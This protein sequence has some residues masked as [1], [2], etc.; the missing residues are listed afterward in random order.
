MKNLVEL[1]GVSK[2]Y[3]L[4]KQKIP[5]LH[6]IDLKIGRG[7]LISIIGPSGS[8]KS[9]LLHLLGLMDHADHGTILFEESNIKKFSENELAH[10]R[11]EKIG[12]VFQDFHL[13]D[14]LSIEDNIALPLLI[15]SG[16]NSLSPNQQ[17]KLEELMKKLGIWDRRHHRP[18]QISGGQ[19][20]RTAIA[21]ALISTPELLLADEPTGNLDQATG[22]QIIGILEKICREDKITM[23]IVTHDHKIAEK[24]DRIIQISEGTISH[25]TLVKKYVV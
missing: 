12:F 19:K 3:L 17:I 1:V 20:Q 7:E 9:T 13:L 23:I 6:G 22:E 18:R 21:R 24:A 16:K 10:L 8:G 25:K 2:N 4:G 14:D 15:R 5:A 11:S